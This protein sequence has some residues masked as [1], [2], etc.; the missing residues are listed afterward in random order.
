MD[1]YLHWYR[2][3]HV[4]MVHIHTPGNIHVCTMLWRKRLHHVLGIVVVV[5]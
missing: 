5:E 3:V 2:R 4:L 1:N